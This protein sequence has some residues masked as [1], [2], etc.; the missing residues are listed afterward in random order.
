MKYIKLACIQAIKESKK[1][2]TASA[3]QVRQELNANTLIPFANQ[4]VKHG[5][6]FG[7]T[8]KLKAIYEKY[9]EQPQMWNLFKKTLGINAT[10]NISLYH[11]LNEKLS[12]YLEQGKLWVN[13][14]KQ[15][16]SEKNK[17]LYFMFLYADKA[18]TVT[19]SINYLL[20]KV[21]SEEKQ[22]IL[23]AFKKY[24]GGFNT[25]A[26]II[27]D[28]F[29]H[30]PVFD[31]MSMPAK[32]YVFWLVWTN[33]AEVSWKVTD[34][35]KG[36]LGLMSWGDLIRS[37]PENGLGLLVQVF[38]PFIPSGMINSSLKIGWNALIIPAM[39]AQFYYLYRRHL[40]DENGNL[41]ESEVQK[42]I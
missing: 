22:I 28:F 29:D 30:H 20:E 42:L 3:Y 5:S 14:H 10:D 12:G 4:I 13:T 38:C 33:V 32:A 21:D 25:F 6:V 26:E 24:N 2:R 8:S 17:Y 31:V 36:F 7:L 15:Q 23:Q 37:L 11:Q 34:I 9:Q 35:T 19:S 39:G 27:E 18:P 40:I 16:L 41:I 1:I